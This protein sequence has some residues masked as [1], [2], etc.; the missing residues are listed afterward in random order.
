MLHIMARIIYNKESRM[1]TSTTINVMHLFF[2]VMSISNTHEYSLVIIADS[3][4]QSL[5]TF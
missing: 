3:V 1:M 4:I 2:V 5:L